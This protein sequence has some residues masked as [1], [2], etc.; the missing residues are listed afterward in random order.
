MVIGSSLTKQNTNLV[1][2]K[3][4][5]NKDAKVNIRILVSGMNARKVGGESHSVENRGFFYEPFE[6]TSKP[7]SPQE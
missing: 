7:T 1:I 4:D 5:E 3:L 2:R 6:T